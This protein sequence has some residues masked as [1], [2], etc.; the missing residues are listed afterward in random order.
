MRNEVL[1]GTRFRAETRLVGVTGVLGIDRLGL[2]D[3]LDSEKSGDRSGIC[4]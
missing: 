4:S 2:G 1:A 3:L